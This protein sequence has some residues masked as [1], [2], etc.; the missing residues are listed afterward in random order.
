MVEI[1]SA[2]PRNDRFLIDPSTRL[3]LAQGDRV[4]LEV[5]LLVFSFGF[6]VLSWG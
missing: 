6:L 4:A 2:S 1:A 3:R 5:T